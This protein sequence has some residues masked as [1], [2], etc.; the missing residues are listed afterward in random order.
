MLIMPMWAMTWQ[1]FIGGEGNPSWL[2]QR[3]WL[4]VGIAVATMALEAWMILEA[5][6]L[7]PRINGVLETSATAEAARA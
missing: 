1:V 2:S 3:N 6:K 5:L 4:L 7:F